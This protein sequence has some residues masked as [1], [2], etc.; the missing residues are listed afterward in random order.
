MA[1]I[2]AHDHKV[3]N[4]LRMVRI[5]WLI[6]SLFLL[7]PVASQAQSVGLVLSGGGAKGLYHIGVLKALEEN[8][9]PI[10]Y[11]SGTSMGAIIGG[12]YATGISPEDIQ[13][14]FESNQ[15]KYWLSGRI[16]N[17]Y[18]FYFKQMYENA[19]M[20]T[21]RFDP[22][23]SKKPAMPWSLIATNQLDM[24]FIEFFAQATAAS[25]GD[26]DKLFVPFRCVA[27]DVIGRQAVVFREGDVGMA[28]R[29]S[30][31][32]PMAFR[33]VQSGSA[34]LYDGGMFDNFPWKVLMQDFNPDILIGSKSVG[35]GE[36]L[37]DDIIDQ[38]FSLTT[39]HTDYELP[40][41]TDIM[42]A[43]VMKDVPI[44]D[45]DKVTYTIEKGYED[46][47]EK[48]DDIKAAIG[49]RSDIAS[50]KA[51]RGEY[52]ESLPP[53]EFEDFTIEGLTEE[54]TEHVNKLLG[55]TDKNDSYDFDKFRYEYFKI[56][57]EG[58][59]EADFPKLTYDTETQKFRLSIPMTTKPSLKLMIGGN[60]SSTALNQA[61]LGLEY[62]TIEH[63]NNRYNLDGYLSTFYSSISL[64][65]RH[66]FVR[67]QSMYVDYG[68][69]ANTY[70]YYRSHSGFLSKG[71]DITYSKFRDYYATTSIGTP[72]SRHSV[73]NFRINSGMTE[74]LYFQNTGY[75]SDD[76]MDRTH[77]GHIGG[78]LELERKNQDFAQH[79]TK[80][81]Y[82][83]ISVI[84]VTGKEKY[85]PGISGS[86][87]GQPRSKH[88]RQWIGARFTR[89]QYMSSRPAK[90]LSIGY[91][92]DAVAT[93]KTNF[94]NEYV[95]NMIYPVF[96]PTP[97]SKIVYMKEFRSDIFA[98]GGII[99]TFHFS[100]NL[101]FRTSAYVFVPNKHK[102]EIDKVK[103]KVRYIVDGTL[104]YQTIFGPASLSISKYDVKKNNWFVAFNFGYT[105]FNKKGLF[106]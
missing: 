68:A 90:W 24:A 52:R 79:P 55:L 6:L 85:M 9:I 47:L 31:T 91:M 53:F 95:A 4:Y 42:I 23:Q 38:V 57:A 25:G 21:L 50:V 71:N 15:I 32:L 7:T 10:D 94:S 86:D 81:I 92:V 14:I 26:F 59:I 99:P 84:G 37:D 83:A 41:E 93:T 36:E 48:M 49:R 17:R 102:T 62:R 72:L 45:F 87:L 12:L 106:Y 103:Q 101:Y 11:I 46:A 33:P 70:N 8:N 16:E 39:L 56:L 40:R 74:Y 51:K 77:F 69:A 67:K 104:I 43:R 61:Y 78:K 18:K 54:Q 98:G 30:M 76:K 105:I 58:E 63:S 35:S 28:V 97:H 22:K 60:I 5:K 34:T 13:E 19:A 1:G 20:L 2:P 27:T 80:G 65:G 88:S 29:A 64:M 66:D 100:E 89:E 82:Q 3:K 96:A 73:L 75:N 44:M